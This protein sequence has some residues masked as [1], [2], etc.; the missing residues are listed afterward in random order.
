M[1]D[2]IRRSREITANS[3]AH[4]IANPIHIMPVMLSR[5]AIRCRSEKPSGE[6][7]SLRFGFCLFGIPEVGNWNAA[8]SL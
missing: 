7:F 8:L 6:G 3:I 5:L 4:V 1:F 2:S